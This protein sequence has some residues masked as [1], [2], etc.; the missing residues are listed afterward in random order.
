MSLYALNAMPC[1]RRVVQGNGAHVHLKKTDDAGYTFHAEIIA[2]GELKGSVYGDGLKVYYNDL[3]VREYL[4][5]TLLPKAGSLAFPVTDALA[6]VKVFTDV[7]VS[8]LAPQ[9]GRLACTNLIAALPGNRL[10]LQPT[11][12][13]TAPSISNAEVALWEAT[14]PGG[15]AVNNLTPIDMAGTLFV[16]SSFHDSFMDVLRGH[17]G[18]DVMVGW[19]KRATLAYS[20]ADRLNRIYSAPQ[21]VQVASA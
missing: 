11:K 15:V 19:Y 4:A 1:S 13:R 8:L 7:A 10:L 20:E 14:N 17:D 5:C 6:N 12:E 3:A 9:L 2:D 18:G 16:L 21:V